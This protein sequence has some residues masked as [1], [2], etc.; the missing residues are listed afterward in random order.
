[1]KWK[2]EEEEYENIHCMPMNLNL[3]FLFYAYR[4]VLGCEKGLNGEIPFS[5]Y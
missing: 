1:M 4:S 3:L 5:L 2:T